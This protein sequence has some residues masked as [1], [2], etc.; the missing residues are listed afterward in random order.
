MRG[1]AAFPKCFIDDI[2]HRR[3]M[4]VF[5]WIELACGL[6]VEGLEMYA[7]FLVRDEPE[8][9]DEVAAAIAAAGFA[10]PLF[11]CSPD[12]TVPDDTLRRRERDR[13]V[14][15]IEI[16]HRLGGAGTVCRVL[17]GQRYPDVSIERGLMWVT[18]AIQSLLPIAAERGVVLGLE[19]HYKDGHWHYPEFAQHQDVFLRLLD[20]VGDHPSFGVQYDPSNA[21]VAGEDPLDLLEC[22]AE[23]VVSMHASD[24]H[25]AP[26]AT[27]DDLR[28][29]EDATGYAAALVHGVVGQGMND[30]DAIF[31]RLAAS[32]FD[33]WVSIEDGM[34]GV[35]EIARSAEFLQSMRQRHFPAHAHQGG[36]A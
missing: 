8:Y 3:T 23:R 34:N 33:G 12:F 30:Y 32:G 2:A 20:A 17:S 26:G 25:L 7:G 4:S 36:R 1:I 13:A 18:E 16:A 29:A 27:L 24:R 9:V 28:A 14:A 19:N 31:A 21:L 6:P 10:M 15:M 35:D 22:V 11:C 5:E